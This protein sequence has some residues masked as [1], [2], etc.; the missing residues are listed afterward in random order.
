MQ[1]SGRLRFGTLLS[2]VALTCV[3]TELL[4]LLRNVLE[5]FNS[6]VQIPVVFW[7][8]DNH[9]TKIPAW[10]T[11][12]PITRVVG[13][14]TFALQNVFQRSME[15]YSETGITVFLP[16]QPKSFLKMHSSPY[17]LFF[18]Y[19]FSDRLVLVSHPP[20]NFADE[21]LLCRRFQIITVNE[22]MIDA[23]DTRS[24]ICTHRVGSVNITGDTF[25]EQDRSKYFRDI[26]VLIDINA[27]AVKRE[28]SY[29]VFP[30][31]VA[32][33]K[34]ITVLNVTPIYSSCPFKGL[35]D[36]LYD[37]V[38]EP[39]SLFYEFSG[40]PN[41][42]GLYG[43]TGVGIFS[44]KVPNAGSSAISSGRS[45]ILAVFLLTVGGALYVLSF[46][47]FSRGFSSDR[48]SICNRVMFLT[49]SMLGRAPPPMRING[50]PLRMLTATWLLGT[51]LFGA[52][53]QSQLTSEFNVPMYA[54][55]VET[56]EDLNKLSR[57]GNMI[58]CIDLA[59]EGYV[60]VI[61]YDYHLGKSAYINLKGLDP[62]NR[63]ECLYRA[64]NGTHA[65]VAEADY[66]TMGKAS[67]MGLSRSSSLIRTKYKFAP[68]QPFYRYVLQHRRLVRTL[69]ESGL[70]IHEQMTASHNIGE[71]TRQ[72]KTFP[73][74]KQI[75]VLAGGWL[76][77][78]VALMGELA[79]SSFFGR[80][81]QQRV[82]TRTRFEVCQLRVDQLCT[83][84]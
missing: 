8:Q 74:S 15:K 52:F 47:L 69:V 81:R 70:I 57:S 63:D 59:Q 4:P 75:M 67:E 41:Q 36:L 83:K 38:T 62:Y 50:D 1:Y 11:K 76:A 30:E 71:E 26:S 73:L 56:L 42:D 78:G 58:P 24:F 17:S 72:V 46:R 35:C 77:S 43:E 84:N 32:Y 51:F 5:Y 53:I 34:A 3:S 10:V 29:D 39:T 7:C 28:A 25:Y 64:R 21:E 66:R 27:S 60:A 48:Y 18:R 54:P 61:A 6:T 9:G 49:A 65:Y 20:F 22:T 40:S 55:S 19:A 23:P 68:A 31:S 12:L 44:W 14:S 82:K 2:I 79:W 13:T 80:R 33:K 45:V 16:F 37:I